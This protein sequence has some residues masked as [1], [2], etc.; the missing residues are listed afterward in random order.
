[1]MEISL[2]FLMVI[3]VSETC[4]LPNGND[5]RL[6]A[7]NS[8]TSASLG[9]SSAELAA[10]ASRFRSSV[11]LTYARGWW[12]AGVPVS[13]LFYFRIYGHSPTPTLA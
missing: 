10:R 12:K 2:R 4:S 11:R 6:G 1:M 13:C 5:A 3:T 9:G 7:I 8:L